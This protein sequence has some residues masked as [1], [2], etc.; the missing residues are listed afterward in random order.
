VQADV[1]EPVH[2]LDD[3]QLEL[4]SRAPDAFTDHGQALASLRALAGELE[5][6]HPDAPKSLRE[7]LEETVA[8]QRLGASEQ[9]VKTLGST[10]PIESI[11]EIVRR[12][13]RNVKSWQDGDMRKRW[14]A[15]GMLEAEHQFRRIVGY[16]DLADLA[17]AVEREVAA[18]PPPNPAREEG[19]RDRYG[20]IVR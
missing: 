12:I 2:E 1:V 19:G 17:V 15:A 6:S 11:I 10:N 20:V 4:G 3:R 9:L 14:T 5:R 16:R 8:L 13:Q 18:A 7:G